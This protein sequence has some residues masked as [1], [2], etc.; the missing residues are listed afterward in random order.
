MSVTRKQEEELKVAGPKLALKINGHLTQAW[1][2]SGLPISSFTIGELKGTLGTR[3]VQ[4]QQLH[5][6]DG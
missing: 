5:P 1:T 4:L 3:N 6:K 2:D